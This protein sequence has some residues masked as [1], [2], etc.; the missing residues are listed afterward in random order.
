[1]PF[2]DVL[3]MLRGNKASYTYTEN[4]YAKKDLPFHLGWIS[5][6]RYLMSTV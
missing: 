4:S 2:K 6:V 1:M 3:D 5:C